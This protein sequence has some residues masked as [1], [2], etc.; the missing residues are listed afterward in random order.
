MG[1]EDPAPRA[2]S[3]TLSW[4][5]LDDRQRKQALAALSVV[6]GLALLEL[7]SVHAICWWGE[8]GWLPWP[9]L[10]D[11]I[12]DYD[13]L[14]HLASGRAIVEQGSVPARDPF[15]FTAGETPWVNT[16][17]LAQVV[18]YQ[19]YKAGGLSLNWLLGRALLVGA[20]ALAH[21]RSRRRASAPWASV[22]VA[23]FVLCALRTAST[24]R[25]QGWTFVLLA[26]ALLLLDSLKERPSR[27]AAAGLLATLVLSEQL[28]GGFVFLYA[29]VGIFLVA[30][31]WDL[32]RGLE[33]ASKRLVLLLAIVIALGLLSFALHPH[34]FRALLHPLSYVRDERVREIFIVNE[35]APTDATSEVGFMVE[36][37]VLAL[38]ALA[39]IAR[40]PWRTADLLLVLVFAHLAF[41]SLRGLHY[42]A[43]VLAAPLAFS[44]EGALEVARERGP[45]LA[46]AA[47]ALLGRLELAARIF[48][49]WLPLALLLAVGTAT[50]QSI[51]KLQR[52]V[53]GDLSSP[54][55][56]LQAD[57]AE[58]ATY[59]D[60]TDPPGNLYNVMEAGGI[61]DW[62]LYP[63]RRIFMD[64]R[65]DL[66]ALSLDQEGHSTWRDSRMI[67]DTKEGWIQALERRRCDLAL[68][69]R[70]TL[71]ERA[72]RAEGWRAARENTT[73][74][75]LV[76]P[77]SPAEKALLP[78]R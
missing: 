37:A 27:A 50:A 53:P 57:V 21:E 11:A 2:A 48:G 46:R 76:R 75:L 29:A 20:V 16:N 61:L 13:E 44:L 17:W 47:L 77:D 19:V 6:L 55:L 71:L 9:V 68:V 63:K 5:R 52:G 74:A 70:Q 34:G 4:L 39:C 23:F 26:L 14:W 72:L 62:R 22:P 12:F 8:H 67:V 7:I 1:L 25:P 56:R 32:W 51:P 60:A 49:R 65:G 10:G 73:Q 38:L 31:V 42:L 69:P 64:G 28:H 40:R 43:I 30:E 59:I 35:L 58:M 66:H 41:Q 15:T 54:L 33:G 18:L 78:Q 24:M 36:G 45:A 3:E